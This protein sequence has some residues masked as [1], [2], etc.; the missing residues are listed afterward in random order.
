MTGRKA[1]V[2]GSGGSQGHIA[3]IIGQIT[4]RANLQ[5]NLQETCVTGNRGG[6]IESLLKPLEHHSNILPSGLK[7]CPQ[8]GTHLCREMQ[9]PM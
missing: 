6:L 4:R 2:H 9:Q 8:L 7:G 3:V 1:K 5:R